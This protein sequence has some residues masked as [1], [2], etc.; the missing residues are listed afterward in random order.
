MNRAFVQR[1]SALRKKL[2]LL[3]AVWLVFSAELHAED[4]LSPAYFGD[5]KVPGGAS[6]A[7]RLGYIDCWGDDRIYTCT[8][9]TPLN[10]FGIQV[11][12]SW[13]EITAL[14][15]YKMKVPN[16]P[17]PLLAG[18]PFTDL[19]YR[20]LFL[21]F[22][23]SDIERLARAIDHSAWVKV[24]YPDHIVYVRDGVDVKMEL[25]EQ[26][27]VLS[28]ATPAYVEEQMVI[29]RKR[30]HEESMNSSKHESF[31]DFMKR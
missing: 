29:F 31:I 23:D 13:V 5:L 27:I 25:F 16:G 21:E 30:M 12:K 7:K 15:T 11:A 17:P 22:S 8:R 19:G 24:V 9:S 26:R 10:F 3:G 14:P 4:Y 20:K 28:P 6:D 18:V 2:L 1:K